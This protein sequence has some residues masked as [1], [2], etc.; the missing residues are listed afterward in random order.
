MPY[1]SSLAPLDELVLDCRHPISAEYLEEAVSCYRAGAFRTSIVATWVALCYDYLGKLAELELTGD[2]EAKRR[3]EEWGEAHRAGKMD[4]LLKLE[5]TFLEAARDNFELISQAEYDE[6]SRLR[7]D[8]HK[9]AHPSHWE[10][11]EPYQPSAEQARTHIRAAVDHMLSREPVQGKAALD[12]VHAAVESEYF[13]DDVQEAAE[14]LQ[15][16]PLGNARDVLVRSATITLLKNALKE[17]ATSDQRLRRLTAIA[18]LHT[19]RTGE[20]EEALDDVADRLFSGLPDDGWASAFAVLRTL[21]FVWDFL[22]PG[23]QRIARTVLERAE[24]K[25]KDGVGVILA[26]LLID[27]L[28]ELVASKT[29]RLSLDN[30][31]TIALVGY[32][33]ELAPE[34]LHRVNIFAGKSGANFLA[35]VIDNN[36]AS[37][38]PD[39]VRNLL[40]SFLANEGLHGIAEFGRGVKALVERAR[41]IGGLQSLVNMKAIREVIQAYDMLEAQRQRIHLEISEHARKII[42]ERLRAVDEGS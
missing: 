1:A 16:G 30:F 39:L 22:S 3:L 9:C 15:S 13:P 35:S 4:K 21:P 5:R 19:F 10:F 18:A 20:V 34:L 26:S 40:E 24:F 37:F 41:E 32:R 36:S 6:L 42:N 31:C 38:S 33:S 23:V 14:R 17:E 12:R 25:G 8:R 28:A 29:R 11:G 27:D 2:A 7:Q